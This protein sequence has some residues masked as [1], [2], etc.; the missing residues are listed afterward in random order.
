MTSGEYSKVL[1]DLSH[2]SRLKSDQLTDNL[3]IFLRSTLGWPQAYLKVTP[4]LLPLLHVEM[5]AE[6]LKDFIGHPHR[7]FFFIHWAISG[8]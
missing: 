2:E 6:D 1:D 7:C 5:S 8:P 3:Y 4:D